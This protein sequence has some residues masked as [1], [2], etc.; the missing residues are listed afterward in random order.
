MLP[1]TLT[2]FFH[3]SKET[4]ENQYTPALKGL[5]KQNQFTGSVGACEGVAPGNRVLWI[6]YPA[7]GSGEGCQVEEA[8]EMNPK[9]HTCQVVPTTP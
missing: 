1:R 5:Q 3:G 6:S 4:E 2:H 7:G 9:P 8:E